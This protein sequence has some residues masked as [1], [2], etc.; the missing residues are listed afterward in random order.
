MNTD[1]IKGKSL[2]TVVKR[3]HQAW[4]CALWIEEERLLQVWL[5]GAGVV[6]NS[7]DIIFSD[8]LR[9]KE[10]IWRVK[11]GNGVQQ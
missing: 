9:A 8:K 1:W 2:E 4:W 3:F 6:V 10:I 5:N 11:N 7:L